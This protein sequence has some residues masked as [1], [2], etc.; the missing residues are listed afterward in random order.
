ML[1][2]VIRHKKKIQPRY[3]CLYI[4]LIIVAA[5]VLL[6]LLWVIVQSFKSGAESINNGPLSLPGKL[7]FSNYSKVWQSSGIGTY[8]LNSVIVTGGGLALSL[9][10]CIPCAY[11]LSRF[12]FFGSG[13]MFAVLSAGVFINVNYIVR[14]MYIMINQFGFAL[15]MDS[16]LTESQL[17]LAIVYAVNSCSFGIFLLSGYLRTLPKGYEEAAKIDGC[18]YWGTLVKIVV[19]LSL[20]SIITVVL[21]NFFSYWNEY[22]IANIFVVD[23]DYFTIMNGLMSVKNSLSTKSEWGQIYAGFVIAMLPTLVLY[24]LAQDKLTKGMS[25]GGLKG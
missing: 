21:F 14:P 13:V 6:P 9:V 12:K 11:V 8:F 17:T 7:L 10:L 24:I 1:A 4:F 25:I 22:L 2:Q 19:P 3:V 16:L 5:T 23:K 15:G 20:P 18:G